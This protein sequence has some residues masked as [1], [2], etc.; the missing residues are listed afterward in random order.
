MQDCKATIHIFDLYRYLN[1]ITYFVIN[2]LTLITNVKTLGKARKRHSE[3][4]N[5]KL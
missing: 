1:T 3:S 5:D 4:L 2:V